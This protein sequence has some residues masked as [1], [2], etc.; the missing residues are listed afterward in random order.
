MLVRNI[1]YCLITNLIIL[2][3]SKRQDKFIKPN[4]SMI[5]SCDAVVNIC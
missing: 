3:G 5:H 1:K 4:Y 2:I